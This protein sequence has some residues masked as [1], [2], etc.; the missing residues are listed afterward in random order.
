M[1]VTVIGTGY[2]GLVS[3]VCLAHRGHQVTCVDLNPRIVERLNAGE[4]TIHE[5]G[6]SELFSEARPRLNFTS[7]LA[8]GCRGSSVI[9]ICVGTPFIGDRIQLD[10]V[11]SAAEGVG[12]A[13]STLDENI[14]R[15]VTLKSTAVPGTTE[16]LVQNNVAKNFSSERFCV[17]M[18]P[19]FL[20]EGVAVADFMEPDRVVIGCSDSRGAALLRELYASFGG[21]R[22]V[23]TPSTAEAIKYASNGLF[24]TLI[25]YANEVAS[26]C[27]TVPGVDA[28]MVEQGLHMDR[29]LRGT[30][31]RPVGATSYLRSGCG[32]GGS[33]F[34]KDVK[35]LAAHGR[36]AG[37]A[38]PLLDAVLSVNAA[39]VSS[40]VG[41]LQTALGP[42]RGKSVAL[43]GL[44]FKP[45]TDDVRESVSLRLAESLLAAGVRLRVHDPVVQ[46]THMAHQGYATL[47]EKFEW[48][49]DPL[50]ASQGVSAVV[51]MT[52]WSEYRH[53]NLR[54]LPTSTYVFDGRRLWP[55]DAIH[56]GR[57][58]SL[59]KGPTPT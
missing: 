24:A 11:T 4:L 55:T 28:V 49:T 23:T 52:A 34:P 12:R 33:C 14:F 9:L 3:G 10:Q 41:Q 43:W 42:L 48:F 19:E 51:L 32:F 27:E 54:E 21:D 56:P 15:V 25:S 20:R 35:A 40:I 16:G 6:L 50:K 30:D 8:E 17:A 38:T 2:V 37:V 36:D 39:R 26:L 31:G 1:K 22:L 57:Y 59:G 18:N 13:L 46:S 47:S 7:D 44:A 29:R 58:L 5:A 45:D 53:I